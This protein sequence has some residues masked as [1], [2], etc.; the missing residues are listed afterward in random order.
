MTSPF[1]YPAELE[2]RA[3]EV[4]IK[5]PL[6]DPA[7]MAQALVQ[8]NGQPHAVGPIYVRI[9]LRQLEEAGGL[10]TLKTQILKEA[11]HHCFLCSAVKP[12]LATPR[13]P[14]PGEGNA[15]WAHG[16]CLWQD[17][18]DR[19][20]SI[21]DLAS[22]VPDLR[23]RCVVCLA[24][25]V[26]EAI[27]TPTGY[28]AHP[29]CL[30]VL[31][32]SRVAWWE[33]LWPASAPPAIDR[34]LM[35]FTEAPRAS[36]VPTLYRGQWWNSCARCAPR[37]RT[38]RCDHC[39]A[40]AWSAWRLSLVLADG[41]CRA[42]RVHSKCMEAHKGVLELADPAAARRCGNKAMTGMDRS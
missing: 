14:T 9:R 17:V 18:I 1:P 38:L 21:D 26:A 11:G 16:H 39:G 12:R 25:P 30:R 42:S 3:H 13:V 41:E 7:T 34:C 40:L 20:G 35:C 22:L 28:Q 4:I 19:N 15:A 8:A 29:Q 2:R 27:E 5:E 32:S 23:L 33:I 6:R 24:R 10:E 36:S 31:R 37:R